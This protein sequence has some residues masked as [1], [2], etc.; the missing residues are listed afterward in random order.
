VPT[1]IMSIH[2]YYICIMSAIPTV[3][4]SKRRGHGRV[5]SPQKSRCRITKCPSVNAG[6]SQN[7]RALPPS[8][9]S[10][11]Y[12][13]VSPR[14]NAEM[15][16]IVPFMEYVGTY[17]LLDV[18]HAQANSVL[19][20]QYSVLVDASSLLSPPF[21]RLRPSLLFGA[22]F[23]CLFYL[24]TYLPAKLTIYLSFNP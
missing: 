7:A 1:K 9:L 3:S 10:V 18:L 5:G 15:N 6:Q 20:T 17:A 23:Q 14:R 12:Q 22:E 2:G 24:P 16:A 4:P 19:S 13:V 21:P 8:L 11:L